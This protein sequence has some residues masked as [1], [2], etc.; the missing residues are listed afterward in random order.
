MC[1][2][3]AKP[4]EKAIDIETLGRCFDAN[5]DGAGFAY[6]NGTDMTIV[7]GLMSMEEFKATYEEHNVGSK[8]A[9]IHFRITTR[10]TNG[11]ENTHPFPLKGGALIHNGTI[12]ELG[13]TGEGKSDTALFAEMVHDMDVDALSRLRPMVEKFISGSRVAAMYASGELLIF[14]ERSWI[15]N[16][17]V[18]YSNSGFRAP[19]VHTPATSN[20]YA[21][22]SG[23]AS[24]YSVNHNDADDGDDDHFGYGSW[25]GMR[26][27]AAGYRGARNPVPGVVVGMLPDRKQTIVVGTHR[28][29][30][31]FRLAYRAD[32]GYSVGYI[33]ERKNGA[34]SKTVWV[35]VN[36]F[37]TS[38]ADKISASDK[39]AEMKRWAMQLDIHRVRAQLSA[40]TRKE[41]I[42]LVNVATK[43]ATRT[44][45]AAESVTAAGVS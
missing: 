36:A 12:S 21:S 24:G 3:I 31:E 7:K 16:D 22:W 30:N 6:S 34:P 5:P 44:S 14:N 41:L 26:G 19:V 17:G 39:T 9:L 29:D 18:M 38:D 40:L 42:E 33:Y 10:G 23:T 15:A 11:P 1:I 4:A 32:V 27:A 13:K 43:S 8:K 2:A 25:A 20:T 37:V 28:D 35:P 45:P